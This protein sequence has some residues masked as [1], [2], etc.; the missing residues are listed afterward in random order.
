[1]CR[2]PSQPMTPVPKTEFAGLVSPARESRSS[3][4]TLGARS[5]VPAGSRH[6]AEVSRWPTK[7]RLFDADLGLVSIG[8]GRSLRRYRP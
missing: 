6:P 8:V 1:M 7:P 2:V 4:V 3:P 5:G